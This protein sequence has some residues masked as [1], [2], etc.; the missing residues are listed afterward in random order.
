MRRRNFV[1]VVAAAA[2]TVFRGESAERIRIGF[3]GGSHSHAVGKAKAIKGLSDW[4]LIGVAEK[5]PKIAAAYEEM[6]VPIVSREAILGDGSIPVV[7]VESAVKDH[8]TD[9]VDVLRAGKHVHIE[10]P[11]AWT[12]AGLEAI[13][14]EARARK[15]LV[16]GGYMWRYNPG[17]QKAIEAAKSRWLGDVYLVRGMM[18][19]LIAAER[20]PEWA[21]FKGG[22][23]FEMGG[24]LIDPIVR[25][26]GKPQR[27]Q[28]VL[29]KH[30]KYNDDLLDNTVAVLEYPSALAIVQ[31]STL[32][33]GAGAHRVFEVQGTNGTA[34]IRP[35][36]Q[37]VFE[38]D[39][40]KAAGPYKA[41]RQRIEFPRY[42]R[43]VDDY[44]ELAA[45]LRGQRSLIVPLE[46]EIAVNDVLLRASE[47]G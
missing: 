11:I 42:E 37:P 8:E 45:V 3:L 29:R 43:Y 23:M 46:H 32:Q 35:L 4:E 12:R 33:P 34:V 28:S 15:R 14:R 31:S 41:G 30:G 20:R 9:A 36:E 7:A 26:L 24:H 10:K 21:V 38:I 25:I 13:E 5:S 40:A 16:Q 47:M 22:Q 39:L 6:G 18:N 27:V 1:P 44:V 19:T 2:G 17:F